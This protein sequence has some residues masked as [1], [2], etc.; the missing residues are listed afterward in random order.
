M[1]IKQLEK[2]YKLDFDAIAEIL[3]EQHITINLEH[4]NDV[5]ELWV[6]II[7]NSLGLKADDKEEDNTRSDKESK[8]K[9]KAYTKPE[10][11]KKK[12]IISCKKTVLH[13]QRVKLFYVS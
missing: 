7:E 10:L 8:P 4:L 3:K 13:S 2:K 6:T 1:N 12:Q 11:S 5:P 9:K